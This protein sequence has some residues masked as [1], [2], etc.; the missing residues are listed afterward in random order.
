M[1]GM[2]YICD[3][4]YRLWLLN[5]QNVTSV[6]E[7]LIVILLNFILVTTC[8]TSDMDYKL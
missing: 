3:V 8:E 2:F 6:A 1:V 5:T 7:E 4:E